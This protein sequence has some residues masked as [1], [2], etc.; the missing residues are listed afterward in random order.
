MSDQAIFQHFDDSKLLSV[1]SVQ[2][3]TV[4]PWLLC[5]Q[6]F[7]GDQQEG[8]DM[9][10]NESEVVGTTRRR[11]KSKALAARTIHGLAHNLM[12]ASEH[13]REDLEE[14]QE[15]TQTRW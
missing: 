12:G 1:E 10:N 9:A 8:A 3:R 11:P 2:F 4:E 7:D 15:S 13:T 6:F 5:L 14:D